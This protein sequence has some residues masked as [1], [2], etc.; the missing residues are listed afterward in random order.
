MRHVH[1]GQKYFYDI[2]ELHQTESKEKW[3]QS[4]G[5]HPSMCVWVCVT[6]TH[7][8]PDTHTHTCT[9]THIHQLYHSSTLSCVGYPKHA[10]THTHSRTCMHTHTHR[11][12][13]HTPVAAQSRLTHVRPIPSRGQDSAEHHVVVAPGLTAVFCPGVGA[14]GRA[15]RASPIS[16]P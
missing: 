7:A 3:N 13:T 15:S 6:H 1:L 5:A 9:N 14:E 12:Y 4:C 11:Q 10:R 8:C 2:C 16:P